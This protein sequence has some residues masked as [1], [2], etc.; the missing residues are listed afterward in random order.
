MNTFPPCFVN[1]KY[2]FS[3]PFS[4]HEFIHVIFKIN[5]CVTID[6]ISQISEISNIEVLS[7]NG[8][9]MY[10]FKLLQVNEL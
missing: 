9:L 10:F 8:L 3:D 4:L 2:F 5:M 7:T 6:L 1:M